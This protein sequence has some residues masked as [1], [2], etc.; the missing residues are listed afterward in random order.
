MENTFNNY[1]IAGAS[2]GIGLEL[3]R[4]LIEKGHTVYALS[5][6]PGPLHGNDRYIHLYHDFLTHDPL[7]DIAAETSGI[8][9]CPGS[10]ILKPFARISK[11]DIDNSYILNA[12]GAL[13]FSQRYLANLKWADSPSIVFFSSVA[14]QTGIPFHTAVAMAKGALEGLTRAMAAELAPKIRVNAVA[15]SLTDTPLA[16]GLLSTGAKIEAARARHPLESVG[17]AKEIATIAYHLL[18]QY[19]WVTGQV[20]NVNGG[21]GTVIR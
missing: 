5:R 3:A 1:I 8:A 9:Y 17:T 13:S 11:E 4:L 7:P 16:A 2:S 12:G 18:T 14:V 6:T 10:I 20:F 19:T 21:F 15:P